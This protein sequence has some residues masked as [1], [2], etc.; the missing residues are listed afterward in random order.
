MVELETNRANF[1]LEQQQLT[2]NLEIQNDEHQQILRL[3]QKEVSDFREVF[4]TFREIKNKYIE[5]IDKEP[6]P[7][8]FETLK[9]LYFKFKEKEEKLTGPKFYVNGIEIDKKTMTCNGERVIM[10]NYL[11]SMEEVLTR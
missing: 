2:K 3:F 4:N 5:I 1:F 7:K 11:G 6:D 8:T 9:E 10:T